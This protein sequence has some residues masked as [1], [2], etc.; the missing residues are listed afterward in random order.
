[1]YI[2]RM[3]KYLA[4]EKSGNDNIIDLIDS[5]YHFDNFE[6]KTIFLMQL[7]HEKELYSSEYVLK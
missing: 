1:M 5:I 2:Y 6:L 3:L 7:M 4:I